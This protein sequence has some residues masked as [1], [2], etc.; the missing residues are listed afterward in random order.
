MWG[1]IVGVALG[2]LLLMLAVSAIRAGEVRLG[3]RVYR[4]GELGFVVSVGLMFAAGTLAAGSAI[5]TGMG[6][7]E[8]VTETIEVPGYSLEV[9]GDWSE[10]EALP[11]APTERELGVVAY[12][13]PDGELMITWRRAASEMPPEEVLASL[14]QPGLRYDRWETTTVDGV[15]GV[16]MEYASPR[17]VVRARALAHELAEGELSWVVASCT[18]DGRGRGCESAVTSLRAV[19]P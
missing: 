11:E 10:M 14:R 16:D 13:G 17:G 1:L 4:H 19:R 3:S 15:A 6:A 7:D 5:S 18:H 8:P 2:G 9:R 12:A